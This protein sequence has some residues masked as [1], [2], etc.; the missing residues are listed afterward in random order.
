MFDVFCILRTSQVH[1]QKDSLYTQFLYGKCFIHTHTHTH[2]YI[3]IYI[4]SVCV[5]VCVCVFQI[6][7]LI[8]FLMFSTCFEPHGFV[9]K[10]TV[11]TS[12][13]CMVFTCIGV[14][15]L[16]GG[17]SLTHTHTHTHIYI[18]VCMCVCVSSFPPARLVTPMHVNTPYKN[19]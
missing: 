12:G 4:Y 17:K 5:C 7:A 3:Y 8:R 11:C 15:S 1:H 13:F 19:R 9:S 16:A 18:C 6:N 2:I 14:T 10:K